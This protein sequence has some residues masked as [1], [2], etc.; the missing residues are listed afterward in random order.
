MFNTHQAFFVPISLTLDVNYCHFD[1]SYGNITSK[2]LHARKLWTL[3]R[4]L[5]IFLF[6]HLAHTVLLHLWTLPRRLITLLPLH[7]LLLYFQKIPLSSHH[8]M[9]QTSWVTPI[10]MEIAAVH[11]RIELKQLLIRLLPFELIIWTKS[12]F[13]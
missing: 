8:F 9:I 5:I 2:I 11:D 3:P 4:R 1:P 10:Y 7:T 12:Y 13:L 6:N